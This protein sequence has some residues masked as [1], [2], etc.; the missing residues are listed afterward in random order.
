M[1]AST[2]PNRYIRLKANMTQYTDDDD[3]EL[4]VTLKEIEETFAKEKWSMVSDAMAKKG[5]LG[6]SAGSLAKRFKSLQ[7]AQ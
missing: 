2:L 1:A 7:E 6:F 5:R 3:I 4:K